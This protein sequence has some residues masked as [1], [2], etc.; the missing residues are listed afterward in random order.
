MG[1][2]CD[3]GRLLRGES[4]RKNKGFDQDRVSPRVSASLRWSP[5]SVGFAI[6]VTPGDL[7]GSVPKQ[8]VT[9]TGA[10]PNPSLEPPEAGLV[11]CMTSCSTGTSASWHTVPP[12]M[13]EAHRAR[14]W[15]FTHESGFGSGHPVGR[16]QRDWSAAGKR[17]AW[18][19]ILPKSVR[20]FGFWN[21][22]VYIALL[23][24]GPTSSSVPTFPSPDFEYIFIFLLYC[25]YYHKS[26]QSRMY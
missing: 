9:G 22:P 10:S 4:Y 3:P 25:M 14:S 26:P 20:D 12:A 6:R 8:R 19:A 15:P 11:F 5:C 17:G 18:G 24:P 21:F 13:S 7:Y 2:R 16:R 1:G 23:P